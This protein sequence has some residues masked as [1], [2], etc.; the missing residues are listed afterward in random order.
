MFFPFPC[1]RCATAGRIFRRSYLIS[2]SF[3][4]AAWGSKSKRFLL[5][6][7]LLSPRILGREIYVNVILANDGVLPNPLRSSVPETTTWSV[8]R[9]TLAEVE[10]GI[11][12]RVLE[13][14]GWVIGGAN[15]AAAKLGLKRTTLLYK[16]R[17]LGI[18]RS[19]QAKQALPTSGTREKEGLT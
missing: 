8:A 14:R 10:R 4:A 11:I 7:R 1:R 2:S 5:P 17:K 9:S 18:T 6:R 13:N 15:G 19:M 3:T 16:I 12:L